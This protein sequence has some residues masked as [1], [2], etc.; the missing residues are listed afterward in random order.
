MEKKLDLH[1]IKHSDVKRLLDDFIW[2]CISNNIMQATIITG[3][4]S[5]MKSISIEVLNEY[6]LEPSNYFNFDGSFLID[7]T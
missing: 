1:G 7:F 2:D 3:N 6:G 4:S 5:I